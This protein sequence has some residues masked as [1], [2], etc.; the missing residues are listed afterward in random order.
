MVLKVVN[1]KVGCQRGNNTSIIRAQGCGFNDNEVGCKRG[2]N[3]SI[4]CTQGCGL[5][6]HQVGWEPWS[7]KRLQILEEAK[8]LG[9]FFSGLL[10]DKSYPVLMNEGNG[11]YFKSLL[12][13]SGIL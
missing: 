12:E 9:D 10:M 11:W 1:D 2:K 6:V 13:K 7:V 5:V 3:T 4:I 8:A